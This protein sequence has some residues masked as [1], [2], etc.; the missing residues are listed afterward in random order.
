V[1]T[2]INVRE[3]PAA[4][5]LRAKLDHQPEFKAPDEAPPPENVPEKKDEK[6]EGRRPPPPR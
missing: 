4:Y 3:Q 6:K 5:A 1:Q 2:L